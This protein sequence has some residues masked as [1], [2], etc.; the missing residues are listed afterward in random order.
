M[1]IRERLHQEIE[2]IPEESLDEILRVVETVTRPQTEPRKGERILEYLMRNQFDGPPDLSEN[3][4][5]YASGEK[6]IDAV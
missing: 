3:L 1:T 4:D 6:R 5:L 2:R